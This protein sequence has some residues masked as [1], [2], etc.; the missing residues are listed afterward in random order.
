L[1]D[2]S[3]WLKRKGWGAKGEFK[4]EWKGSANFSGCGRGERGAAAGDGGK[5]KRCDALLGAG[6]E[7]RA[8]KM[9]LGEDQRG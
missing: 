9:H 3:P 8:I 1:P 6:E 5:K 4:K 2:P 7:D